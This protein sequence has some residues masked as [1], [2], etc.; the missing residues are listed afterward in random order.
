MALVCLTW[1]I[2]SPACGK[3]KENKLWANK[4]DKNKDKKILLPTQI[5]KKIFHLVA[6]KISQENSQAIAF[7][8]LI[9]GA[10]NCC[11]PR[12]FAI[13]NSQRSFARSDSEL[14]HR[15][16]KKKKNRL[17]RAKVKY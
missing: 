5:Q 13:I 3:A 9:D 6:L 2:T 7:L 10:A 11:K 16:K 14:A 12:V 4:V 17:G 8:C 15:K 1:I